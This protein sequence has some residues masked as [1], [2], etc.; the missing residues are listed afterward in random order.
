MKRMIRGLLIVTVLIV[1]QAMP[2]QAT[3][4]KI[5]GDVC[6][7][8]GAAVEYPI[9]QGQTTTVTVEG[10]LVD[11]STRLEVSGSGVT[12]SNAGTSS[13]KKSIKIVVRADAEPGLRTVK[14]R[15]LVEATGPDTFKILV[16]RSG[17]VTNVDVPSPSQYFNSVDIVLT[18]ENIGNAG[19]VASSFN[20]QPSGVQIV[21]DNTASRAVVRLQFSS[22]LAEASGI[23][24]LYDKDCD[25]CSN[26]NSL[27]FSKLRYAGI[28][29]GGRNNVSIIGPNAV[30]EITFPNG[31]S[32]RVGSLLAIKIKLVRPAKASTSRS[33]PII[34]I[35]STGGETVHWQLVPST[36][37]E[38]A[39]GS[40]IAFSP[41]GLNQVRIPPGDQFVILTVRL[42]QVPGNCPQQGCQG[43]AQTRMINLNTDQSPFFKRANFT[44]LPAN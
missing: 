24:F 22:L 30:S 15:Y 36:V 26:S 37:F 31:N 8:C 29:D 12:V 40:G 28:N 44:I 16:V 13:G 2:A 1:F 6:S 39:P 11:L 20:P 25:L 17:R 3:I 4:T 32:V 21:G 38:A 19:V 7:N 23:I 35:G 43:Q 27:S 18:G 10:P 41:T 33:S 34:T 14:L 9:R 5:V 42:S